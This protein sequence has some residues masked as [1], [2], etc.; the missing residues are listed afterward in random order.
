MNRLTFSIIAA[1]LVAAIGT[2]GYVLWKQQTRSGV[3]VAGTPPAT[4]AP[5]LPAVPDQAEGTPAP[6]AETP[7]TAASEPAVQYPV[8][9]DADSKAA[10][11]T[12]KARLPSPAQSDNVVSKAVSQVVSRKDV[13][14]FLQ[15]DGFP[16]RLVATVDNLARPHAAPLL[17][18]LVPTPGRFSTVPVAATG[19]KAA[20][21]VISPANAARYTPLVRFVES[22]DSAKAAAVYVRLYPLFQQTY[23]ELGYPR[24]YFN[25]RL[26]AVIDHLIATPTPDAPPRVR[27]TQVKGPIDSV[28][29]WV[30]YEF[31]DPRLEAMSSGQKMLVRTGIDNQVRLQT[32]L[33]DLRG[34]I[35]SGGPERSAAARP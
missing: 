29:P 11:R 5:A 33:K 2:S 23:E 26:V 34:H 28:R 15:L 22:V 21:E 35:V 30:R 17:W 18:P 1:I 4:T 6:V 16:R 24:R 19:G 7:A 8:Q 14:T 32:K 9:A 12:G 20:G 25:D 13:L 10:G 27:L 31:E 3:F